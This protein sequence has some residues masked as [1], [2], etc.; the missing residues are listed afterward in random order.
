M[1]NFAFAICTL[2]IFSCKK[3]I[4]ESTPKSE[5]KTGYI[6]TSLLLEKYEKFKDENEKFKVKSEE[7]GRVV[8][9]K[10]TQLQAEMDNFQRNAQANG[11]AWAQQK[12]QEL[13]QREQQILQERDQVFAKIDE[14]GNKLKDTLVKQVKQQIEDFGK[15]ENYDYIFTTSD[16]NVT[17]IFAKKQY[18]LTQKMI[19][20]LNDEYKKVK[21]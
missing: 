6:D 18:D 8:Q 11:Q 1:K 5:F 13:R 12:A 14:E 21:K 10:A 15:K 2:L 4:K 20:L 16:A 9:A 19:K 7:K 3:E 17:V